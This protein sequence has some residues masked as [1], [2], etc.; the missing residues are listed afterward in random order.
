MLCEGTSLRVEG[1][2][3]TSDR[4]GNTRSEVPIEVS[5]DAPGPLPCSGVVE[6]SGAGDPSWEG[7]SE[8]RGW[9]D[10]L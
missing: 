8:R 6:V 1:S 5:C 4:I 3:E 9:S 7:C 2:S 10:I